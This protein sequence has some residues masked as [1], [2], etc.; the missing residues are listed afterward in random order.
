MKILYSIA[1]AL[2]SL[3]GLYLCVFSEQEV[4]GMLWLVLAGI[5][6]INTKLH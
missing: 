2:F 3:L 4:V 5:A 1:T 6:S